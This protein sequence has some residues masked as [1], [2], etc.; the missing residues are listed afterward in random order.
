[1]VYVKGQPVAAYSMQS[2]EHSCY[3]SLLGLHFGPR[4]V[5]DCSTELFGQMK[6]ALS[7]LTW[8]NDSGDEL[9]RRF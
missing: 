3:S 7:L 6:L 2:A 5:H 8:P 1:M 9:L 4:F